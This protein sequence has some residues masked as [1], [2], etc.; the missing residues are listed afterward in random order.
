MARDLIPQQ[1]GQGNLGNQARRWNNTYTNE[2]YFSGD[3]TSLTTAPTFTSGVFSQFY[4]SGEL[5]LNFGT[6]NDLYHNFGVTPQCIK[7]NLIC[8]VNDRGFLVG[9]KFFP[10]WEQMDD[11]S[12]G[13]T[14]GV[15]ILIN[16]S[17]DPTN[18]LEWAMAS[19]GRWHVLDANGI[20]DALLTA[21]RWRIRFYI[22]A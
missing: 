6:N 14:T 16:Q 5:S 1:A 11:S 8:K 7:F 15:N 17:A 12:T 18:K 9:E 20:G 4:D 2:L 10:S 13:Q 3:G 22:Y 21:S 19:S